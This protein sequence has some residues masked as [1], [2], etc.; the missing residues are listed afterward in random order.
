[1]SYKPGPR[2]TIRSGLSGLIDWVAH[3]FIRVDNSLNMQRTRWTPI[4]TFDTPG[5]LNVSYDIQTGYQWRNQE[6]MFL[7]CHLSATPTFSTSS[8]ELKITGLNKLALPG[9][10]GD[11]YPLPISV[12]QGQGLSWVNG[13]RTQLIAKIRGGENWIHL[14]G[15]IGGGDNGVLDAGDVTSG[16]PLEIAITGF[17]PFEVRG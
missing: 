9:Q 6:L 17:Y 5:D 16:D 15:Q 8:G 3:E 14:T 12:V 11:G 10:T 1:M 13:T 7:H 2:P 4:F